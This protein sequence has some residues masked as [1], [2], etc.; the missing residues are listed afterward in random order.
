MAGSLAAKLMSVAAIANG[1]GVAAASAGGLI[2]A[3]QSAGVVGISAGTS[4]AIGVG[5]GTAGGLAVSKIIKKSKE[6]KKVCV[7]F[8]AHACST[9]KSEISKILLFFF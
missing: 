9:G 1:G 3:A 8:G 7:N 5:A 2:A 6:K 4:L